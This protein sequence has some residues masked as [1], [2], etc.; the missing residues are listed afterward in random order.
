MTKQKRSRG[1]LRPSFAPR[2][3]KSSG[4]NPV[5]R[6]RRWYR[7][8]ISITP[9][10]KKSGRRNADRRVNLPSASAD[11]AARPDLSSLSRVRGGRVGRARL[12]AF[13]RGAC[14]SEPTPPLSSRTRF[15]G[16]GLLQALPEEGLSR[17]S[18]LLAGR[19]WCRPGVFPEPPGDG[20]DEPPPAGNRTRTGRRRHRAAV[21]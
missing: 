12:S 6:R 10:L 19:S 21:L 7:A 3:T 14:G 9:G 1:A 11:A 15:L 4:P 16:L 8:S 13:H 17:S 2:K 18:E 20:S 5:G